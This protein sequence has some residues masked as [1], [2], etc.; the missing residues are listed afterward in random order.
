[1]KK[2]VL[3][4]SG[5]VDSVVLLDMLSR[6]NHHLVVAHVDHGIRDDSTA[7]ARFVEALAKQ[8]KVPFVTKRFE[9][10]EDAS[11]DEARQARYS[12]L[13]E[14]SKKLEAQL[15]TAHHQNDMIE[16]IALNLRRGTGWRGLAV[17]NRH[18]IDRPLLAFP[19]SALIRY[20][21]NHHLEWVEDSTNQSDAYTR[22]QLRKSLHGRLSAD[23]VARLANLR[24]KQVQLSRDIAIQ[25][26]RHVAAYQ[27]D[28]H[29]L[30]VLEEPV[31]L[32]LLGAFVVSAGG[33]RPPR[34][35]LKRAL[36]AVKT[37]K[38]GTSHDIGNGVKM[39]FT[40]RNYQLTV[41]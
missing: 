32:E 14:Q 33:V 10:G 37:A 41:V 13:F 20:A 19:K 22:N 4:V 30:T 31:A 35:Q 11:E 5:G 1:M 23:T 7:D 39:S 29:F 21:L 34:P 8:Y 36:L 24:A 27:G 26:D 3:A 18:E 2:Y 40:T 38:P 25:T 6:S 15:V 9:L 12:F 17:L 16:T 28:R